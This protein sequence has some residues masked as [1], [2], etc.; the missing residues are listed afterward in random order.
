MRHDY[1][2]EL[3]LSLAT[4]RRRRGEQPDD[5]SNPFDP[6]HKWA[7]ASIELLAALV[8]SVPGLADYEMLVAG[9]ARK[10]VR[11]GDYPMVRELILPA[12]KRVQKAI[13]KQSR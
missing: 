7:V 11:D 9:E 4:L 12:M 13:E 10:C 2:P 8:K 1:P 6:E 3:C 5:W